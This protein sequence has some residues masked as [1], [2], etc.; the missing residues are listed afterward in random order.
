MEGASR[1]VLQAT[2]TQYALHHRHLEHQL[3][4]FFIELDARNAKL[5][6]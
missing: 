5:L 3:T 1:D 2:Q 4:V 6:A